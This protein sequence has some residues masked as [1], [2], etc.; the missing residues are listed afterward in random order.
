MTVLLFQNPFIVVFVA[1]V[2]RTWANKWTFSIGCAEVRWRAVIVRWVCTLHLAILAF[3]GARSV[4][5]VAE[6]MGFP[7]G[8]V[9]LVAFLLNSSVAHKWTFTPLR[10]LAP[11]VGSHLVIEV[12]GLCTLDLVPRA[13]GRVA[14][15]REVLA[16]FLTVFPA[17]LFGFCTC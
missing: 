17:K 3:E 4:L 8:V 7:R 5:V 10:V 16:K 15:I 14:R 12:S 11:L 13:V 1:N 2:L 9:V 6:F